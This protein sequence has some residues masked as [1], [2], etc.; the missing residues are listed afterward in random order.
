VAIARAFKTV[1]GYSTLDQVPKDGKQNT[2]S[3][4]QQCVAFLARVRLR[5]DDDQIISRQ[6]TAFAEN[7][8][9][10]HDKL[11]FETGAR[12]LP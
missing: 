3:R 11:L 8:F 2:C 7:S 10:H 1:P 4:A 5:R 6:P 9:T 12:K